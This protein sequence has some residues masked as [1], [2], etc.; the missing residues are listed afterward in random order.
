MALLQIHD[1]AILKARAPLPSEPPPGELELRE[2]FQDQTAEIIAGH[3]RLGRRIP[4]ERIER[5]F[6]H[7][8]R[9][10]QLSRNGIPT[11][12]TWAVS[13]SA[14]YIDELAWAL[15]LQT[16]EI[17]LRDVF[18]SADARGSRLFTQMTRL[19]THAVNPDCATI[20]SDVDWSNRPSMRAHTAAGFQIWRR[21]RAIVV[22]DRLLLRS[23]IDDWHLP[24]AQLAPELRALWWTKARLQQHAALIA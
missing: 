13:G 16:H 15:P 22:A 6:R 21:S 10:F 17:W 5:R 8:L 20:W 19:M 11:G 23:N 18:V 2:L 4:A 24:I 9:F 14:R 12:S 1:I 7:G 3:T